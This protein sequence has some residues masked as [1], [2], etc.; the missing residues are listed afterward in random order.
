MKS[1]S[2]PVTWEVYGR[3]VIEANTLE[4]A[5]AKA[6]DD[7]GVIP[8]PDENDYVD[9]SWRLTEEDVETVRSLYNNNEKDDL[10]E[11]NNGK[12]KR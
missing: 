1:W 6:R 2:I 12:K 3:V 8:L 4:E 9:G 10:E 5:M 7:E 11:K